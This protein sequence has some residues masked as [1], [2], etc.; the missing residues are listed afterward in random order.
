MCCRLV[1]ILLVGLVGG[2]LLL[3]AA[4]VRA[5]A[6]LLTAEP[7]PGMQLPSAPSVIK[8]VFNESLGDGSTFTLFDATFKQIS[9]SV[10]RD[11][12]APS[13]LLADNVPELS[14]GVY[15]VQWL[16]VS[17]DGH[18][19]SGSY[20]FSIGD[21]MLT[22]TLLAEGA[23][24]PPHWVGWLMVILALALPTAVYYWQ[25]SQRP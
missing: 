15:T 9:V 2:A 23:F 20:E 22:S 21:Q 14:K 7:A 5:H 24:N 6:E 4:V 18:P 8:L 13:T 25:K 16:A 12:D 3:S 10:A 11:K 19:L 1:R 17:Q